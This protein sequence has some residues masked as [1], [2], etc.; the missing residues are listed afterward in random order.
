MPPL[1]PQTHGHGSG[2]DVVRS[3]PFG[4]SPARE[5]RV[6]DA[7]HSG[8]ARMLWW[9]LRTTR[10]GHTLELWVMS[11]ALAV[12]SGDDTVRICCS[13]RTAQAVADYCN[14]SLLTSRI[15]D[16]IWEQG[17]RL[18][19]TILSPGKRPVP[20]DIL[21]DLGLPTGTLADMAD[22]P[23]MVE[24]HRRMERER[25]GRTG[26]LAN[27]GKH[28]VLTNRLVGRPY[29][30]ANYGL[31]DTRSPNGKV[32]QTVG[33]AHD[34]EHTDYSQTLVLVARGCTLDGASADLH[35]IMKDPATAPL[36]S[37]EGPLHLTRPAGLIA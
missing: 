32:W 18:S 25:A 7:V 30:A 23:R 28:W 35:E 15:A 13:C 6:L 29:R 26:L 37:D 33:L 5:Q 24:A 34:T 11:D 10:M 20:K 16:L 31:F 12:G 17:V 27:V 4:P 8:C 2:L 1:P 3:M 36:V 14:A 22:T 19:P 21:S 9:P